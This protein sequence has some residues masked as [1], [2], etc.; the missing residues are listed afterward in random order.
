[1][2]IVILTGTIDAVEIKT[3]SGGKD[4]ALLNLLVTNDFGTQTTIETIP[5]IAFGKAVNHCRS[6]S[7]GQS[8]TIQARAT[9]RMNDKG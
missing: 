6:V 4:Y 5:L 3:S 7:P 2:N 9:A 8:A 1:M